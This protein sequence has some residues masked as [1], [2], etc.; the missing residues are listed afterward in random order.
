MKAQRYSRR[1][2]LVQLGGAVAGVH[3]ATAC[4]PFSLSATSSTSTPGSTSPAVVMTGGALVIGQLAQILNTNPY[5]TGSAQALFRWSMF[6]P[7]VTLDSSAQPVPALAESWTWSSD[8]RTLTF[9]LRHDV[10]FHSGRVFSAEDAKWNIEYAQ[11]PKS[12]AISG[13]ELRGVQASA[14]AND[15]L[16]LKL[17]GPTP[18][19][20]SLL[21]DVLMIDAESDVALK[22]GGTGP[23]KFGGLQPGVEMHLV[24]NEHYWK[25]ERPHL[26]AVT[27]KTF[28]DPAAAVINVETGAAGVVQCAPGDVPRLNTGSQTMAVVY[29]GPGNW[30]YYISAVDPPFTDKRVRQAINFAL[31]RERLGQTLLYGAD[32]PTYLMW[33]E[34]SPAWDASLDVG[35]FN[36]EKAHQLLADA[37]YPNGFDTE[38]VSSDAIPALLKFDEIVQADLAKIGVTAKIQALDFTAANTMLIQGQF[39]AIL[40]SAY[41]NADVDPAMLFTTFSW[42]PDANGSRFHSDQYSQLVTTARQ[43]PDWNKRLA[44]Y[45]QIAALVKDEAFVLPVANAISV[46]GVQSNVQGLVRQPIGPYPNLEDIWLA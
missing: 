26:D 5:P 28:S 44:L 11:D 31:D 38:I 40:T 18:H 33:V 8:F 14:V 20:F 12:Q 15:V 19:I 29:P 10:T 1:Q 22:A 36:L 42:R 37:G 35:E 16:E 32:K 46:W 41:I 45:R 9:K 24:R 23:F 34:R 27:I 3:L 39:H 2:M 4:A 30:A 43:E 17:A 21:Q 25:P 6:N 13:A 7:L